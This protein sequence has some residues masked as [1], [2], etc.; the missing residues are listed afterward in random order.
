[1]AAAPSRPLGSSELLPGR[2]AAQG[3]HG[4]DLRVEPGDELALLGRRHGVDLLDRLHHQD[5]GEPRGHP[6]PDPL[7]CRGRADEEAAVEGWNE[8]R[9]GPA[10]GG[11][12]L[13]SQ[14]LGELLARERAPMTERGRIE[15]GPHAAPVRHHEEG[16]ALRRQHPP[17]LPQ[18]GGDMV[19]ELQFMHH[20]SDIDAAV[21]EGK[22]GVVHQG[23]PSRLFRRPVHDALGCRHEGDDP[24]CLIAPSIQIGHGKTK[25]EHCRPA[26]APEAGAHA[27]REEPARRVTESAGIELSQIDHVHGAAVLIT[28]VG[29][30]SITE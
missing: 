30:I 29:A 17:E 24:L 13:A 26:R 3:G 16:S 15:A 20:E 25:P 2:V 19:R 9:V 12:V 8:E 5:A 14:D 6:E 28:V 7:P 4:R 11:K 27:V 18:H 21:G 23:G 1:M 10:G 22:L